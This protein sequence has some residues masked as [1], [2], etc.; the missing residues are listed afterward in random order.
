[1]RDREGD[2]RWR[3]EGEGEEEEGE[4]RHTEKRYTVDRLAV[5][6][7]DD[8]RARVW[9]WAWRGRVGCLSGG[10]CVVEER[11]RGRQTIKKSFYKSES[12]RKKEASRPPPP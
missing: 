10:V 3:G 8:E 7:G 1:M 2:R 4:E 6:K 9:V 11:G 12:E 5:R